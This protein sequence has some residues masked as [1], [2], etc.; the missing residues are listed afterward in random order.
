M[1][2]ITLDHFT[3]AN[4]LYI[5]IAESYPVANASATSPNVNDAITGLITKVERD[6]LL[7][8]LGLTAY[9]ELILALADI[10]NPTNA[11]WKKLVQGDEYDDIVWEGLDNDYSLLAYQVKA[12]YLFLNAQN[13]HGVGVVQP[14]PEKGIFVSPQHEIANMSTTFVKKYQ[15]NYLNEPEIYCDGRFI[16]WLGINNDEV[17]VSLYRYLYDK[18]D[19]FPSVDLQK[20]R[21]YEPYNSFGI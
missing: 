10:N 4:A 19:D 17:E 9:N 7:H 6:V 20:Y 11:K 5:P 21:F 16:D 1:P 14:N 3:K 15:G 18:K 8:A 13:L 12:E 2:I